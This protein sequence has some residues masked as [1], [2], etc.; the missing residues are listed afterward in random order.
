MKSNFSEDEI[1]ELRRIGD[2]PWLWLLKIFPE[3]RNWTN[4][5]FDLIDTAKVVWQDTQQ[6]RIPLCFQVELQSQTTSAPLATIRDVSELQKRQ[7]LKNSS[8]VF[9][10]DLDGNVIDEI[11]IGREILT[12]EAMN[13]SRLRQCFVIWIGEELQIYCKG[14]PWDP[15]NRLQVLS[16]SKSKRRERIMSMA[17]HRHVLDTHYDRCIRGEASACYWFSGKKNQVLQELPERIFQKSLVDFL[18]RE[19]DCLMADPQPMFRDSTRCDIKVFL[20]NYDLYFIEIKWIGYSA[21]RIRGKAVV[22][23]ESPSEFKVEHA[24]DGAYQTKMYIDDNNAKEFDHRIKLGIYLVYDAYPNPAIPIS[25]GAEI[26]DYPL[27][28][29]IE[30]A[31]VTDP[32]SVRSRGIAKRKG[33]A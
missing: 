6:I 18:N 10:L 24:I 4:K 33:L 2:E 19:V 11:G 26:V 28:D 20:D 7:N 29:T 5:L 16:E 3:A 15:R 9:V 32:P 23:A 22:S 8:L 30:Y 17:D 27:L 21:K 25:Y 14:Y 1:R 13:L 31:L 12:R